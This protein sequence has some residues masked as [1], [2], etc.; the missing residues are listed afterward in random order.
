MK[1]LPRW[2]PIVVVAVVLTLITR[3]VLLRS[4][5]PALFSPEE[6][7][8]AELATHLLEHGQLLRPLSTYQYTAHAGGS[9]V[10]SLLH[11]PFAWVLGP[12]ERSL[13]CVALL[14]AMLSSG[15]WTAAGCR[16]NQQTGW[17]VAMGTVLAPLHL[18]FRQLTALGNHAEALAL[19]GG[20]VLL[21]QG[22]R[23][24]WLGL[25]LGFGV[26]FD[27][28]V[29][30]FAVCCLPSV[31][32]KDWPRLAAG[33]AIGVCPMLL[34]AG[35]ELPGATLASQFRLQ[36]HLELPL[37]PPLSG[38]PHW[39]LAGLSLAALGLGLAQRRPDVRLCVLFVGGFVLLWSFYT[40]RNLHVQ[41]VLTLPLLFT[42]A[43]LTGRARL[44][45]VSAVWL[46]AGSAT[47]DGQQTLCPDSVRAPR[48][49][50]LALAQA[51]VWW[52][53]PQDVEALQDWLDE[54]A[55]EP[56]TFGRYFQ[57]S[58]DSPGLFTWRFFGA[59]GPDGTL[60]RDICFADDVGMPTIE[61]VDQALGPL[62]GAQAQA[63]ARARAIR[64][65]RRPD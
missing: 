9:L 52:Y 23:W 58:A 50:G 2:T 60:T 11:V 37:L 51:N 6:L 3:A 44:V 34:Q 59:I 54:G 27:R 26:W 13:K 14:F 57:Y 55:P 25:V 22:G 49:D 7:F 19:M 4:L 35:T 18:V 47:V 41:T 33:A 45:G 32:V 29:A 42:A 65:G 16:V 5:A 53:R 61:Q 20:A 63:A 15:L 48:I 64:S 46:L 24:F 8:N 1:R 28:T 30:L 40:A 21:L 10:V 62:E 12:S 43:S 31:P 56:D 38:G 39:P 17:L 36:P